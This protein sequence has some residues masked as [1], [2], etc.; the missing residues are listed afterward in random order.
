[1]T[2]NHFLPMRDAQ[3]LRVAERPVDK[4]S[5]GIASPHA[6]FVSHNRFPVRK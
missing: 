6:K 1:M 3:F 2:K 5:T 4:N